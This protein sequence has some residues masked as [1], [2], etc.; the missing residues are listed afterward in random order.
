QLITRMFPHLETRHSRL[1]LI[2]AELK[3]MST[4]YR[5]RLDLVLGCAAMSMGIHALNVGA[6]YLVGRMLFPTMKTTLV[7]HFL[8]V[9]LTLFPMVVPIPFGAVGVS[10]AAGEQLF[11]LVRHPDGALG[12]MGFRVVMYGGA[13]VGA[14]VYLAKLKEVRALTASAHH[15]EDALL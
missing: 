5:R 1:G 12:M 13:L 2:A 4:T 3:V 10:E 8:M 7:D 15:L 9:P 14:L 6:F 11:G